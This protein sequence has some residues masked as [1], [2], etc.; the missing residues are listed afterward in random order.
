MARIAAQQAVQTQALEKKLGYDLQVSD[1]FTLLTNAISV[2]VQYGDLQK[3]N[4][5]PGVKA[6]F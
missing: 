1:H 3:L 4:R 5:Q 2:T 6:A